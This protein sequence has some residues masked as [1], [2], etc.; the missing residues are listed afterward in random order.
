METTEP[1]FWGVSVLEFGDVLM[2]EKF[3]KKICRE[4]WEKHACSA[5]K[6]IIVAV[7]FGCTVND[8]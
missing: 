6:T 5:S 2:L 1:C 7:F 3:P 4:D 8:L